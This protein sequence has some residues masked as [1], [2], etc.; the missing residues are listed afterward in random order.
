MK[1]IL[2]LCGGTGAWS[3]PY[4]E[5]GYDV[6]LITLPDY[7]VEEVS[8]F[9]DHMTFKK[10]NCF[11][12]DMNLHYSE[13]YGILAAPPCTEFS[14]AKNGKHRSRDLEEGMIVVEACMKIIWTV[15]KRG[16]LE[17]W[18]L[19]NP[20]G[21]LRRFLG[22]P[23][24]TLEQWQYGGKFVK[25]TDIWGFFNIP[26]ATVKERPEGLTVKQPSGRTIAAEW[27]KLEYPPEYEAYMSM[28]DWD[29]KRAACRAITPPGFADAF[30]KANR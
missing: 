13:V 15:Q 27:S 2:D 11:V 21:L 5:N 29:G 19:E 28:Y 12:S 10:Q 24:F 26:T 9:P 14:I 17:F 22:V 1:V 23:E 8:F 4:V 18:A 3:R 25:A 16:R 7:C 20:R 30:Y 6:R